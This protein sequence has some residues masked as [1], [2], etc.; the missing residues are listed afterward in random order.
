M[1]PNQCLALVTHL[2]VRGHRVGVGCC[3]FWVTRTPQVVKG[4]IPTSQKPS[5]VL[6]CLTQGR[7]GTV[8]TNKTAGRESMKIKANTH[9]VGSLEGDLGRVLGTLLGL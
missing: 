6:D 3:C 5:C 2:G 9:T 1:R 4:V 7:Q 8:A